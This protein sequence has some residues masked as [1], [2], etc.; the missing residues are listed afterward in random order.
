MYRFIFSCVIVCLLFSCEKQVRTPNVYI[1]RTAAVGTLDCSGAEVSGRIFL[2]EEVNDVYVKV[3]YSEGNGKMYNSQYVNS[4][5]V[6]GL[7]ASLSSDSLALGSGSVV[8]RITGTPSS[9]GIAQFE[10]SLG[11]KSCSFSVNVEESKPT[12]GYGPEIKDVDG[13]VYKTVFIGSQ[14]WMAENLKTSKYNDG[15]EIPNVKNSSDWWK[16]TT[17]AWSYYNSDSSFN[18]KYGKLYNWRATNPEYNGYKNV[19][20]FGWHVPSDKDWSLL[21]D[22]VGGIYNGGSK[23]KEV[24]NSSWKTQNT[25]AVNS[26][27]FTALPGGLL[28]YSFISVGEGSLGYWWS[29]DKYDSYFGNCIELRKDNGVINRYRNVFN[30]GMSIRCIK[31]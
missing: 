14:H 15:T 29:S 13:N 8:F 22:S 16:L 6:T 23:L 18:V 17:G 24:G 21:I 31:D 19:C 7:M 30:V 9:T 28:N 1:D 27:L 25:D 20:P 12:S 11:G 26:S 10:I 4:T 2:G 5:N 3:A